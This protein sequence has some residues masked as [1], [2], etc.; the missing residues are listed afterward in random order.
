[1][2]KI[3]PRQKPKTDAKPP[4]FQT[5]AVNR[6]ARFEYDVLET[7]EAGLSLMGTEIKAIREGRVSIQEAYARPE[8]GELLLLNCHIPPYSA[9]NVHNHDPLRP[10]KL[11]LHR[12][13]I[14][15]LIGKVSQKG[16]TLIPLRLYIKGH[17]AKVDL[18]LCRGRKLY[19]KREVTAR[20]EDEREMA[21]ELKSRR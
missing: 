1:M 11:L 14:V 2:A 12:E 10:R 19:D 13:E 17:W 16:Y 18:G 4:V 21:R 7:V 20:R 6:R 9:G 5:I 3:P 8:G 15:A